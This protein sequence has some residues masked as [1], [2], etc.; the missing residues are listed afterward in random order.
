MPRSPAKPA[1]ADHRPPDLLRGLRRRF[2][3]DGAARRRIIASLGENVYVKIPVTTTSGESMAPLVRE[4]CGEGVKLNVTALF[5]PA[6]VELITDAVQATAPP[7]CI[8]VF[9]GRIADAGVTP[10][11][12]WP[13]P[14]RS[15]P[16]P[17]SSELIW[18]SP[19]EMLNLVQADEVG[20]HIITVTHDLLAKLDLPRQGPR[21]VLA[22][23][24]ADVPW[25]RGGR[26]IR[27]LTGRWSHR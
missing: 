7:S 20:C 11:R 6:Q 12:S 3:G 24:R 4:L 8:S 25:R 1:R 23:D 26:R 17:R 18:A 15:W 19:R 5:T 9:A 14:W 2:R 13:G 21:A 22:R 10:C 16:R 27:A